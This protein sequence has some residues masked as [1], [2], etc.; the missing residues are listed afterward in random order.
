MF[1]IRNLIVVNLLTRQIKNI[2]LSLILLSI[3]I[4]AQTETEHWNAKK[5]NYKI[6]EISQHNYSFDS[7]TPAMML[8]SG[9]HNAYSFLI[10]DYDGDNCPF[11]PTCSNFLVRSVKETNILQGVLMF[12]D[13]FTR[14]LNFIERE[15]YARTKKGKLIDL[16]RNYKLKENEIIILENK[17]PAESK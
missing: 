10:S 13:R 16:P 12:S 4:F 17:K 1:L 8:V 2:V 7:S 14:D 9:L 3:T 11:T 6:R 5:P 15:K